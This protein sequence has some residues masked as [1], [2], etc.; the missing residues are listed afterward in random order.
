MYEENPHT[1][2]VEYGLQIKYSIFV[3]KYKNSGFRFIFSKKNLIYFKSLY[4]N[5]FW[6]QTTTISDGS[7]KYPLLC[8]MLIYL[9]KLYKIRLIITSTYQSFRKLI[10]LLEMYQK[11]S[12]PE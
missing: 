2:L 1:T 10:L 4:L 7:K 6:Y 9:Q 8:R 3:S 11:S 5:L 12:D